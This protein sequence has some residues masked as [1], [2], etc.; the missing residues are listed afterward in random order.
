MSNYF[1]INKWSDRIQSHL[2]QAASSSANQGNN[3][4]T[5][6]AD[7]PKKDLKRT[8]TIANITRDDAPVILKENYLLSKTNSTAHIPENSRTKNTKRTYANFDKDLAIRMFGYRVIYQKPEENCSDD[9]N[10]DSKDAPQII[11]QA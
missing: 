5:G 9:T 3:H 2:N 8:D 4:S 1:D 11:T 7:S 10:A 6:V